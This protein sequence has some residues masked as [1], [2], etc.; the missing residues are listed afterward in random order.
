VLCG[1]ALAIGTA[2]H[3]AAAKGN[4]S[5]KDVQLGSRPKPQT[6]GEN[7]DLV[8]AFLAGPMAGVE[9]IVFAVHGVIPE[10]WY[11]NIGYLSTDRDQIMTGK[12]GKLCKLNVRT[13]KLTVLLD[14]PE[15][16][17]RDPCVHYDGRRI[18]FAYRKGTTENYLLYTINAD[19]TGLRQITEGTYDDYE[20][21]WLPDGGIVFVTTRANRWVNCW[22]TQVGNIWRCDA[23]GRNMRAL[24]AN[25]EQDNTPWVLPDGRI[26]YMRWEYIDRNQVTFHHLWTMYPDGTGQTVFFGNLNPGGVFIDAKPIP[27]SD[28][29]VLSNSP[30]HGRTEHEGFVARVSAKRGPD[31]LDSLRNINRKPNCRDPWAFGDDAFMAAELN[32]LVLISSSGQWATLFTLPKAFGP[33][34]LHEPRP[35]VAHPKEFVIPQRA[36]LSRST[37]KFMLDNVYH[38]RNMAGVKPGEI[39]RLMVIETLPKPIN[40]TGGMDPLSYKGT[41]TSATTRRSCR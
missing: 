25:L 33:V 19:G 4:Q 26:L 24:S 30:G 18:L 41:F 35:I 37:G 31:Q 17:M 21:C 27:G 1:F 15:G 36:D 12:N 32:K 23:D 11:A 8:K 29:V 40:F 38:G 6:T 13:G 34:W 9:E 22:L 2:S 3:A 7:P 5:K 28:D 14:D 16:S 39:K 10:H 20:P